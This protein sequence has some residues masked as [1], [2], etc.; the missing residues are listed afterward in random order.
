[1]KTNHD[2]MLEL[3]SEIDDGCCYQYLNVG[4][5][6]IYECFLIRCSDDR[7]CHTYELHSAEEIDLI[8]NALTNIKS[9][10]K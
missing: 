6:D 10:L 7:S 5:C 2:K 1:M 8:I 3:E 4:Y 9:K